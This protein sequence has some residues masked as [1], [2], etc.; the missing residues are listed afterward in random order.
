MKCREEAHQARADQRG[1]L[2][3]A[4][5]PPWHGC[6]AV[7]APS[8]LRAT[9][10]QG[11]SLTLQLQALDRKNGVDTLAY[12]IRDAAPAGYQTYA[13]MDAYIEELLNA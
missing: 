7:R 10:E 4:N 8:H 11:L 1:P 12:G 5:L 6:P 9:S 3:K 2:R 13:W